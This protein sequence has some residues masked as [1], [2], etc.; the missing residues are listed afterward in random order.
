VEKCEG[1]FDPAKVE[2]VMLNLL[3][4]ACEA[5]S[6]DTGKVEVT[7]RVTVEG[8][9]IRVGDNGPGIPESIRENLF[10]PFVSFGKEKGTGLGLTVVQKIMQ[11]HGGEVCVERTDANGSTFKLLFPQRY[12][13]LQEVNL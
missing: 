2:R 10:Q 8:I 9:E 3:F 11:D 7:S 4:N 1:W 6:P 12:E 13:A 5:V